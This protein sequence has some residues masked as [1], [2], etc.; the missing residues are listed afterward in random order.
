[1]QEFIL[2]LSRVQN[3]LSSSLEKVHSQLAVEYMAVLNTVQHALKS[4]FGASRR[5][6]EALYLQV[7]LESARRTFS[8]TDTLH[9]KLSTTQVA[10]L[11]SYVADLHSH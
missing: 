10:V 9:R 6:M 2:I 3:A 4:T 1:M 5:S 11:A 7:L 8:S